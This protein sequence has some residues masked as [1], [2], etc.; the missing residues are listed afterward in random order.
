MALPI[1]G[2]SEA[3]MESKQL[4]ISCP[5][6]SSRILVDVRTGSILRTL[7]AGEADETGKP[8]VGERDWSEAL[9]KVSKRTTE[10]PGKLDA[11]LQKER[12][13]TSRLDD[14]FKQA[15]E[16]LKKKEDP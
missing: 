6:C 9:G 16:T 1:Q 3:F 15:S 12:D 5:C 2:R 8:K 13:K 10:A 7:R 14:L 11:A 4:E